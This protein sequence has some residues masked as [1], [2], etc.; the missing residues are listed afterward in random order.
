MTKKKI[1]FVEDDAK[2]RKSIAN[3]L[4]NEGYEVTDVGD[5]LDAIEQFSLNE[6]DLI[7]SDLM[8]DSI[9]GIRFLRYVKKMNPIVKTMILTAE[10]TIDSEL[11]SLDLKVDRYLSKQTRV[12]VILKYIEA[13]LALYTESDDLQPRATKL[14]STLDKVVLDMEARIVTKNDIPV[15]LTAKEFGITKVLLENIG[16]AVSRYEL[17]EEVWDVE[18]ENIDARVIDVHIRA[19]RQKLKLQSIVSVR[20]F[21]YK[22][23]V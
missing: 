1:L 18:H 22:W 4:R 11:E 20:S 6:Y 23:D 16:K 9:D 13:T 19:I 2:Y 8:M 15:E 12:D 10:P 3:V 17:I 14:T 5:A 7:I 21:G